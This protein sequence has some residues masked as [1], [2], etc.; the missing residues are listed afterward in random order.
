MALRGLPRVGRGPEPG[1]AGEWRHVPE[2]ETRRGIREGGCREEGVG[3]GAARG[4]PTP[5][6]RCPAGTR[7]PQG[8]VLGAG[9]PPSCAWAA[10]RVQGCPPRVSPSPRG[11]PSS[12]IP[13]Q[14]PSEV[15][16]GRGQ[17]KKPRWQPPRETEARSR[18]E[19]A[20]GPRRVL[21]PGEPPARF[22]SFPLFLRGFLG[23]LWPR[24]LELGGLFLD[25]IKSCWCCWCRAPRVARR[26]YSRWV[27]RH[28]LPGGCSPTRGGSG[29]QGCPPPEGRAGVVR[30][31]CGQGPD[32]AE[33]DASEPV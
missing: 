24:W 21:L 14:Q 1:G 28:L 8:G 30:P 4:G 31:A 23:N 18:R 33:L 16:G 7:A 13:P 5:R 20:A 10:G 17:K 22:I 26:E 25:A 3:L 32:F 15:P 27:P 29:C 12:G 19:S 11:V 2:P 6:A 9:C